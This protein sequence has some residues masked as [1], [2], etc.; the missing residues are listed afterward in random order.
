MSEIIDDDC[1]TR[2][3]AALQKARANPITAKMVAFLAVPHPGDAVMSLWDR[4]SDFVRPPSE[5]VRLLAGYRVAITFEE[6]P[7]G[8]CLHLSVSNDATGEMPSHKTVAD[9]AVACHATVPIAAMATP[10]WVEEFKIGDGL[11][12]IAV[13]LLLIVAKP[14]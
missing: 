8:L 5:H 3:A 10:A 7:P 4:G 2:L 11:G 14:N 13:N 1:R 6:Q 9:I 12:G